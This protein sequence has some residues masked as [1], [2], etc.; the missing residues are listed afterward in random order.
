MISRYEF[1]TERGTFQIIRGEDGRWSIWL[2][3]ERFTAP[4]AYVSA[5]QAVSD[6]SGGHSDWPGIDDPS[7]LGI[8]DELN[9]WKAFRS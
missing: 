1:T 4:S 7:R 3:A 6:L 9:E 2:N 8:P 5:E